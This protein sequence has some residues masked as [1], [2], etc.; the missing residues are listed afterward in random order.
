MLQV[1]GSDG[2]DVADRPSLMALLDEVLG[3]GDL[4]ITMGAG[5]VTTVGPDYLEH[6]SDLEMKGDR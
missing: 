2:R 5:D 1:V 6:V 3:E 4:L